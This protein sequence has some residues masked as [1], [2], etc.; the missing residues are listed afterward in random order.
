MAKPTPSKLADAYQTYPTASAAASAALR[1]ITNKKYETGG[2]VLYNKEQNVYAATDPGGRERRR[3]LRG[4][5][6]RAAGLEPTQHLSRPP[7]R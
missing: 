4:G 2:G 6:E 7:V 1:G 3:T 5:G